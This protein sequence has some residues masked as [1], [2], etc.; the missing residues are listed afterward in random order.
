M[1]AQELSGI[2]SWLGQSPAGYRN[3]AS[4]GTSNTW[5]TWNVVGGRPHR[6][7]PATDART[8]VPAAPGSTGT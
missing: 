1:T 6:V 7:R 2:K 8:E 5:P 3:T 4:S